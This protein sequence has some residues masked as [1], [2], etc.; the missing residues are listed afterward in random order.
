MDLSNLGREFVQ[1]GLL[2]SISQFVGGSREV[3]RRT[4]GAALPTTMY[5]IAD[6]G[7]TEFGA[8]GLLE[9][10]RNGSAPQLDVGD[11]GRTLRDPQAS[12]QLLRGSGGFLDKLMGHKLDGFVGGLSALGGGDRSVTSKILALVAPLALGVVGRRV[13]ET[14]LDP[15][16]LAAFLSVEKAKVATLVPDSLRSFVGAPPVEHQ[17]IPEVPVRPAP[18]VVPHVVRAPEPAHTHWSLVAAGIAA[19]FG[20]GWLIAR[21]LHAPHA[22][23]VS[24]PRLPETRTPG[25]PPPGR[26]STTT[27]SE[28][29]PAP[30]PAGTSPV[31]AWL[32]SNPTQPRRFTLDGIRFATGDSSLNQVAQRSVGELATALE[33]HPDATI[34]IEGF[35]GSLGN[36]ATGGNLGEARADAVKAALVS[37]GIDGNRIY[38]AAGSA[39]GA[40]GSRV[41]AVVTPK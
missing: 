27:P 13:R 23:T 8:A 28:I 29:G 33:A 36:D 4:L 31:A 26:P 19:L 15:R 3:T 7:S 38:T 6:H 21:S 2:D 40:E 25:T 9:G 32:A 14:N 34:R 5:S 18:P 12:D 11:L 22:P 20:L 30:P 17:V 37:A 24:A 41:E 39:G 35:G 16:G 1:G 10:L